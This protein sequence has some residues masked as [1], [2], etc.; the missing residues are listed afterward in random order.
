MSL[1]IR[2]ETPADILAIDTVTITAFLHAPH[3][4]HTEQHIVTALRHAGA[5]SVSL[6]AEQDGAIIGHIALS[7]VH[8]SDGTKNW[9]GLG[10][11]SVLPTHQKNGI[12][13]A[14]MNESLSALRELG[15]QGCVLLGDPGYYRRFGFA[16]VPGLTL[17][18]VPPE[19]FMALPLG[20]QTSHQTPQGRVT[21]HA[22]FGA[23]T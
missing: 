21:Y 11:I 15:A 1:R 4:S 6:V 13:A 2:P 9:Y 17:D 16:P 22:A 18:G 8:I 7:P 20:T 23:T 19:Y 10:P 5:L 3:T 12:G 14:L